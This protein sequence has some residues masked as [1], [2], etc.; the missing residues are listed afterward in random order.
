MSGSSLV[1]NQ[2]AVTGMEVVLGGVV[3]VVAQPEAPED[4]KTDRK[5][6]TNIPSSADLKEE[7]TRVSRETHLKLVLKNAFFAVLAV[8]A[9]AVL[10]SMLFMPVMRIYGTSMSPT[11]NE[12]NI[13]AA[14]KS[15]TLEQGDIVAFYYN[16]KV[17]VKRVIAGSGSWVDISED[18]KVSVDGQELDEPYVEE[19]ALGESDI[20][21][22]YQVPESRYFVIG[23]NRAVSIDS[24]SSSIGT[25]AEDQIIG[26]MML[27]IWPLAEFGL[28]K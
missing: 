8:S 16:N 10:L 13:V 14:V 20:T 9:V 1:D 3:S 2:Q 4:S 28:V 11:L 21:F 18:G 22:P 5:P 24:R 17:L 12:G 7:L 27:R 23:D 15:P 6:Y 26:K 25:I 19:L